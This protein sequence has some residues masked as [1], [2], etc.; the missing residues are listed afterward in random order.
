VENNEQHSTSTH[1][2]QTQTAGI[3]VRIVHAPSLSRSLYLDK[4][5]VILFGLSC[6]FGS[7]EGSLDLANTK[8]TVVVLNY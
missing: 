3:T 5:I 7:I 2:S 4:R 8:V 1:R 6:D